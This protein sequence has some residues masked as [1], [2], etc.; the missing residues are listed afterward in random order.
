M[1]STCF[2]F[3]II[4]SAALACNQSQQQPAT[5]RPASLNGSYRLLNSWQIKNGD[6]LN[7]TPPAGLETIKLFNDNHF[8]FFSHD[9]NKGKDSAATFGAGSGTYQLSGNEYKEHLQFCSYR[10]WENRDF[11]FQLEIKQDTLIQKGIEKIDSLQVN[12][13]II[14]VYVKMPAAK[15]E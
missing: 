5:S 10:E 13:E 7:T 9:L 8:A 14:E 12:H 11:S 2:A 6:T 1:K 15:T 4:A 3:T